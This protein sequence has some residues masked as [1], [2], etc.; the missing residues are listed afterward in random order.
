VPLLSRI[1]EE[2]DERGR[3]VADIYNRVADRLIGQ[4]PLERAPLIHMTALIE[5]SDL[6]QR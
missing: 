2:G 3:L 6:N 4:P 5:A 1:D